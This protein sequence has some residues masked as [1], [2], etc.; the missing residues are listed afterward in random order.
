MVDPL[1][2]VQQAEKTDL[3]KGKKVKKNKLQ[4][5]NI[6]EIA[7]FGAMMKTFFASDLFQDSEEAVRNENK[8]S[9]SRPTN[10][11]QVL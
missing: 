4:I 1:E 3:E 2:T 8:A 7:F 10:L 5:K 6:I 11:S 9:S